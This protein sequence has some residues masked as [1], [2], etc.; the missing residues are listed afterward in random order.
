MNSSRETTIRSLEAK[1]ILGYGLCISLLLLLGLLRYRT[2]LRLAADDQWV[3]HSEKVLNFLHRLDANYTR[4]ETAH[5]AYLL[6]STRPNLQ[7]WRLAQAETDLSLQQVRELTVDNLTQ[8]QQIDALTRLLKDHRAQRNPESSA[9]QESGRLPADWSARLAFDRVAQKE[10]Q[11]QILQLFNE[12]RYLLMS[13][14]RAASN[15]VRRTAV[16]VAGGSIL[17]LGLLISV[18]FLS[19]RDFSG[20][21]LAEAGLQHERDLLR[22]LMDNVPDMIYFK[23]ARGRFTRIN[24]GQARKLGLQS[25]GEA[26]GKTQTHFLD[27]EQATSI[28]AKEEHVLRSGEPLLAHVEPIRFADGQ[29][30]WVSATKVPIR[31]SAGAVTGLVSIARDI[32]G[33]KQAEEALEKSKAELERRVE[34]RTALLSQSNEM[35]QGEIEERRTAEEALRESEEKYRLL[36]ESNP[37]PMWVYDLETLKLLAVN[38]S[39]CQQYGY[40][41]DEFMS[42]TITDIRPEEDREAVRLAAAQASSLEARV[43]GWRHLKKDGSVIDVEVFSRAVTFNG[44]RSRLV[45]AQDV[46]ARNRAKAEVN[47]LNQTLEQRVAE[48]TVQLE[49]ANKDLEAFSYSVSHDLRAPLRQ[50]AGFSRIL[51]ED[52]AEQI[53]EKA[54][55]YFKRVIDATDRMSML[56]DHLLRLSRVSRQDLA[57]RPADLNAVLRAS[58]DDVRDSSDGRKIEWEIGS[59]PVITCDPDLVRQVFTNLLSNALKFTRMREPAVIRVDQATEKDRTVIFVKDNGAGFDMKYA[60]RLFAAFQ[61]LHPVEEFEGTGVGLATVDRIIRRHGGEIWAESQPGKGAIFYFTLGP[62]VAEKQAQA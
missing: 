47:L 60:A 35:L 54:Q 38:D 27:S 32:T 42:L 36:F 49:A 15:A 19:H 30:R 23:D 40:S 34:D 39:A 58:L 20:R 10:I 31:D 44:R 16:L 17:I 45:L 18:I 13:R 57:R 1:I 4:E 21:R 9:S 12:E 53:D 50:V 48:R 6:A 24:G 5:A 56:I 3:E 33:L 43:S 55:H 46:T 61:R 22:A 59:L 26:V 62:A 25:P 2:S 8:Q 51:L 7:S 28:E 37:N 52:C 29:T 11:S 41:K 14:H